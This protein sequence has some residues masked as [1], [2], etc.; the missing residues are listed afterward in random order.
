[1]ALGMWIYILLGG[2]NLHPF[3]GIGTWFALM[4]SSVIVCNEGFFRKL[5]GQ[6][7]DDYIDEQLNKKLALRERYIVSKA[8]TFEDLSTGCLCHI[9]ET[10]EGGSICLYGQY[11]YDYVGITDDPEL[12]QPRMFPTSEFTLIRDKKNREILRVDIGDKVI[13]ETIIE[14]P[15]IERL[16][17]LGINL[18]DGELIKKIAFNKI[19][20]VIV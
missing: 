1:M 20:E 12:N 7:D 9:I 8:L 4:F 16:Y 15:K 6:S 3:I 5:K 14:S 2:G 17:D 10:E 11:L 13:E 19:L 18:N